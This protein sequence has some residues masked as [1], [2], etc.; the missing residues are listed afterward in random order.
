MQSLGASL[1]NILLAA[2]ELGIV[3]FLKGAPLFCRDAVRDALD[4]PA[5][6][7][8]AFLVLLGYPSDDAQVAPRD[9]FRLEDF[10][11]ER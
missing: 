4:L 2:T 9:D 7:E 6:W 5:D 3:G 11:L 1:Q 10:M 8:P